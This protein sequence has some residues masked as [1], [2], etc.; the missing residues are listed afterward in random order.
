MSKLVLTPT[1]S[2]STPLM[3]EVV[4]ER[5]VQEGMSRVFFNSRLFPATPS[6][7]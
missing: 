4:E 1:K 6:T 7:W 5:E 2:Y 3:K